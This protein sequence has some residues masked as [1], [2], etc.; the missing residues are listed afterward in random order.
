MNFELI[1]KTL[2]QQDARIKELEDKLAGVHT[3]VIKLINGLFNTTTQAGAIN[4]H[5]SALLEYTSSTH[6]QPTTEWESL[7]TTRQGDENARRIEKLEKI[8]NSPQFGQNNNS[9][10]KQRSYSEDSF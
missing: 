6:C 3:T 9:F 8:I 7:P 4:S 10:K 2:L 1:E 5:L